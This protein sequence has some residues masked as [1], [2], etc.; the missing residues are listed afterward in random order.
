MFRQELSSEIANRAVYPKYRQFKN[1][2]NT[3]ELPSKRITDLKA[4]ANS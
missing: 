1:V 4:Y 3:M 2:H